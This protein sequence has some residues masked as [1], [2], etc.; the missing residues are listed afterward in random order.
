M[1]ILTPDALAKVMEEV[2]EWKSWAV[3]CRHLEA[4]RAAGDWPDPDTDAADLSIE[5]KLVDDCEKIV[6]P[7]CDAVETLAAERTRL[8]EALS[9]IAKEYCPIL[10]AGLR[11]DLL[12]GPRRFT[13]ED[14][15]KVRPEHKWTHDHE[16][17]F[18]GF[19][20]TA[21]A[22]WDAIAILVEVKE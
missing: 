20:C 1:S 19:F 17:E 22:I 14:G 12:V 16:G 10:C 18:Y 13:W 11:K 8:R 4:K 2:A 6:E 3:V 9:G 21:G 5:D 15:G 7:L